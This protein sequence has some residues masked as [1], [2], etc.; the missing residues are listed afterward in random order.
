[1]DYITPKPVS[2]GVLLAV[3]AVAFAVAAA[4]AA[5]F[6]F[7]R[8]LRFLKPS[9][10][11]VAWTLAGAYFLFFGAAALARHYAMATCGLDLGY[12]ANAIYNFGRGNFFVQT[13]LPADGFI[14][15]C[16]PLLAALAP[17]TYVF[18]DPAYLLPLQTLL[19]AA[20]I[21]LVYAVARP[22]AGS[23]WPAAA[24]AASFALSPALHGAALFDFHPRALA[25]P[26][27]L[28][29][30][31]FFDRK[32][33]GAGLA[34]A[35]VMALAHEELALHAVALVAY[36]GFA[37]G[38]RRA[39]LVAAGVLAAYCVGLCCLLYPKLTY[40]PHAGPLGHWFLRR[41]LD[42]TACAA[43]GDGIAA[44]ASEKAG[45]LGA[46]VAPVAAF[47]PAAGGFLFAAL[48]PLAVPAASS[49]APAF[50]IGC[51]YPLAVA[52]F[53]F[54]A[55]AVGARRLVR[56]SPGA[57]RAF[58]IA[59]GSA[60]A[61]VV[62]LLL[63]I[64]FAGSYY[65]PTFAAAF[66]TDHDKALAGA[67]KRVPANVPACADDPLISHL[68]HREYA[69]FYP[70]C[71]DVDLPAKPEALLLNRCHYVPGDLPA[72]LERAA[73]WNLTLQACDVDSAYFAL[74]PRRQTDDELFRCWFGAVQEWQCRS[75]SAE[76]VVR[77]DGALDG[78]A[79]LAQQ[80]LRHEGPHDYLYPPGRYCLT[81]RLRPDKGFCRVV[82]SAHFTDP[83][84]DS[85]FRFRRA[86]KVLWSDCG[87]QP[88][89]LRLKS[90]RPFRLKFNV[91]ATA[92]FYFDAV[93]VDGK[94]F[95]FAA[96]REL[97]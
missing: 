48:T 35:A 39:G 90:P 97:P 13:L 44:V 68:A 46:L 49:V 20:G 84:D 76:R 54:G 80:E 40:A 74:G 95:T 21:P 6:V 67:L 9:P 87:Y 42:Y 79:I 43:A 55:A 85:K 33:F 89:R 15:H 27:A 23:R 60:A 7:R 61:V 19:I 38:R 28:G 71:R 82:Y 93:S 69:Y 73:A 92:P 17:F 16:A 72:I 70:H 22:A 56:P 53:L 58:L 47:L 37:A 50:K 24:L 26:L 10:G 3:A 5:A 36:G 11:G 94:D 8:R 63:I 2:L 59:A 31:Y 14:N 83:D 78:R 65:R 77:D 12:Y 96:L 52:P 29:A 45:Y 81:F 25:V 64:A 4:A 51:Q 66:P 34:C 1:M 18:R 91:R 30:F 88:C 86:S 41:H 75:P 57:A 32:R 62:Q